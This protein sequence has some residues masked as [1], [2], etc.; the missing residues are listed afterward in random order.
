[1]GYVSDIRKMVGSRPLI[2]VG[3][4]LLAL[5][6]DNELLLIKRTDNGCW[7]V[8]GGSMELGESLEDTLKRE[9]KEEIG[10]DL[11]DFELFGIYSGTSQYYKYPNGDEVFV[12]ATVFITR[13]PLNNMMVDP[14]EHSESRYFDIHHLPDNISPP[15]VPILNDLQKWLDD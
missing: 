13:V 11:K 3:A 6:E 9:T 5:N 7:G 10:V 2:I 15:V 1:M 4:T 8:P 14:V 12:V